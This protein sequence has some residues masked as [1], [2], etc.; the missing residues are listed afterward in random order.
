MTIAFRDIFE[1][2]SFRDPLEPEDHFSICPV[3]GAD[4]DL[5]DYPEGIRQ[6]D[7]GYE[8]KEDF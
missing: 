8:F 7:C 1:V 2:P 6:C 5:D 4:F 3:C